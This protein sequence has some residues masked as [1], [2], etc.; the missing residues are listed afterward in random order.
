M[1]TTNQSVGPLSNIDMNAMAPAAEQMSSKP[2]QPG[3]SPTSPET[4]ESWKAF[5]LMKHQWEHYLNPPKTGSLKS[6]E[7]HLREAA[8][9]GHMGASRELSDILLRR[10]DHSQSVCYALLALAGAE[11][12]STAEK[13]TLS[14]SQHQAERR[15]T[16]YARQ[17]SSLA[18]SRQP[19]G[20]V[21]DIDKAQNLMTTLRSA[22]PAL[23]EPNP[24]LCW[25]RHLSRDLKSITR[26]LIAAN[27][28]KLAA[29][30]CQEVLAAVPLHYPDWFPGNPG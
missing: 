26:S 22:L 15:Q 5:N 24:S 9:L 8:D 16:H 19:D 3:Y 17:M 28:A 14:Q 30:F 4:E 10:G 23:Q 20:Y 11:A 6:P 18:Q 27:E 2:P 12:V 7:H 21:L 13:L 1:F 29:E 25:N